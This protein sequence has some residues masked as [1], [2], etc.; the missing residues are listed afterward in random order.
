MSFEDITIQRNWPIVNGY[1]QMP[2][3]LEKDKTKIGYTDGLTLGGQFANLSTGTCAT[4]GGKH[5]VQTWIT[6]EAGVGDIDTTANLIKADQVS[7]P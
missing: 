7:P 6:T 1:L 3:N 5:G 2:D 4:A